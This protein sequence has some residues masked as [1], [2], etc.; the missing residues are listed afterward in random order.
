MSK[1]NGTLLGSPPLM[2]RETI[3]LTD[4]E[5]KIFDRLLQVLSHFNLETQLRVAGGW[6]R[7]KLL[8][9]ECHDIDI[10]LDN[11]LG[12]EFCEKVEEYLI[13]TGEDMRSFHVIKSNPNKSKHLETA[14]MRLF[15]VSIDF[16]NLRSE[17]YV[18]NSRIPTMRFGSAEQD[19]YRRDLT[20]NSLFYNINTCL[21]EDFTGR[22]LD[23]LRTGKIVTPLPPKKTF[24]DDPLRVLRAIRFSD[25]FEFEMVEELKAAAK[26][27]DVKSAI[28]DKISRERVGK[29]VDPMV[30]GNQPAKAMGYISEL[31]LFW[32]VFTPPPNCEPPISKD[33]D[34][35][36]VR[37]M[38]AGLRLM[39]KI[40]RR[41]TNEQRRLYLYASLFL[42]LRKTV[43]KDDKGKMLP[44]SDHVFLDSLKLKASYADGVTM[45]HKAVEKFLILIPF[46]SS[47]SNLNE[48]TQIPEINWEP[49]IIDVPVKLKSRILL[50]LLLKE[51]KD[52]WRVALVIS[53][54]LYKESIV[55]QEILKLEESKDLFM[56]VEQEILKLDLEKIW[57]NWKMKPLI[58]GNEIMRVL[59]LEKG[60]PVVG[61]WE[62]KLVQW[63]LAYPSGGEVEC[64][65]WMMR[66]TQLKR[67]RT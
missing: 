1:T 28:S 25:R 4:M 60:G 16:V 20:I 56:E 48:V 47:N 50:G 23:D 14:K 13:F 10:A 9:K 2:V 62:R 34:R 7:D 31:G 38:E 52:L 3:D 11:M 51:I 21:V 44:F 45:L 46:V 64:V 66:E 5:K 17:D 36:C 55:D 63:Q 57:E 29:E 54:L 35:V 27:N 8:G 58:N 12:R 53:T 67:A 37:C 24:L 43:Y 61:E 15:D 42:P 22:G 26:E 30:S 49:E 32:V 18:E 59:G 19:A 65:D 39:N 6:V 41:F 33:L 40:G